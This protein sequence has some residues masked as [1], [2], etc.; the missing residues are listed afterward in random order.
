MIL[1]GSR[2]EPLALWSTALLVGG[3]VL[4]LIGRRLAARS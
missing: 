3:V 2:V 4:M 1:L